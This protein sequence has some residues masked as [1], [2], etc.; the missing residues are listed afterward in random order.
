MLLPV[1]SFRKG[2]VM[3]EQWSTL[4]GLVEAYKEHLRG[5]RG[6]RE[7]TLRGYERLVR[8]FV[9]ASLGE[10]PI[11]SR[12]IGCSDVVEF[13]ALMQARFSPR[14][15]KTVRTALRS[16]FRFL[17]VEGLCDERLE[18]AIPRVAFWRLATLPCCL[19]GEQLTRL[20]ASLDASGS[21]G[22][23]DRAIA[24][25]LASLGLRPGEIANLRLDDI[26]WRAGTLCLRERKTRRGALLPLPCEAGRAIAYYLREERPA[27]D[28]RHVFVQHSDARRGR[29][30]SSNAVSAVVVRALQRAGVEPPLAGAYVLRHTLASRLV[31]QGASLKEVADLLGHRSL[32]TTAIYAKLDLAAL[33]EVALPWP[34]EVTR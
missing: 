33:R 25:C 6:L 21:C 4:D 27:T 32:D 23:R 18:A 3:T 22:R 29:P 19:S 2:A 5:T 7:Q 24:V 13:V 8:L 15:L 1:L 30:L 26:D 20:L 14:S 12:R 11:D 31:N 17:R 9:R 28:E 16:F 34:E 10:D